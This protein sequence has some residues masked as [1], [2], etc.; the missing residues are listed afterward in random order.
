MRSRGSCV[1]LAW[2]LALAALGGLATAGNPEQPI[3]PTARQAHPLSGSL[4]DEQRVLTDRI[5]ELEESLKKVE[6]STTTDWRPTAGRPSYTV[7]G[8][9]FVDTC[10]MDQDELNRAQFGD[11]QGGTGFR[12][13]RL[14]ARGNISDVITGEIS[15]EFAGIAT[16]GEQTVQRTSI[17]NV[18]LQWNDL[19]LVQKV[20]LGHIREPASLEDMT[21][22][23][24]YALP[25]RSVLAA[26]IPGRNLGIRAMGH[27]EAEDATFAVGL[28]RETPD[29]PALYDSDVGGHALT[30]RG[31]W[32]PWYDEATAGRSLLHLGGYYSFRDVDN[33]TLRFC[34]RAD[35][36]FG[37]VIVDTGTMTGVVDWHLLGAEAAAVLGPF[38]I[39]SEYAMAMVNRSGASDPRFDALYVEATYFLTGENRNYNRSLGV[40]DRP[41]PHEDA[42]RVRDEHGN[43]ATGTGAWQVAYRYGYIDLVDAGVDGNRASVHS[44]GVNWYL[45]PYSRLMAHYTYG[46]CDVTRAG[47]PGGP[48][49][50]SRQSVLFRAQFDF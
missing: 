6:A 21:S 48:G 34:R 17:T 32:L 38:S 29:M 49:T 35:T 28:F 44:M 36:T 5:A 3:P 25:E 10:L 47:H 27:S 19:P 33:D 16:V 46:L 7:F 40:F 42:F 24:F 15:L 12:S 45:T 13:T 4:L 20:R 9:V 26:F 50:S 18:Y 11:A 30:M 8:R 1:R 39:Q 2:F 43:V 23:R 41:H 22:S 37:P 31:T 14:G